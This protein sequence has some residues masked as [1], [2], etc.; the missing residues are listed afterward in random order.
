MFAVF[1]SEPSSVFELVFV[2]FFVQAPV[3]APPSAPIDCVHRGS[4]D[5]ELIQRPGPLL[6][7]LVGDASIA[8][9]IAQLHLKQLLLYLRVQHS[10]QLQPSQYRR[11]STR[12]LTFASLQ[13]LW[14]IDYNYRIA[15]S[16]FFLMDLIKLL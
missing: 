2:D 6:V 1:E 14:Q 15:F 3:T 16:L 8:P 4:I 7:V 5:Q 12:G 11:H 10:L 9:W 13:P